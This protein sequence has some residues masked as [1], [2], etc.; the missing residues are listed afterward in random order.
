MDRLSRVW[1]LALATLLAFLEHP[2]RVI[3]T[4]LRFLWREFPPVLNR[5][6]LLLGGSL[7]QVPRSRR[8]R[9]VLVAGAIV[10]LLYSAAFYWVEQQVPK[11]EPVDEYVY[12]SQGWG[13]S[14][15]SPDRM[16][17][18]YSPQG[19]HIKNIRYDWFVKL[20]RPWSQDRFAASQ[21]MRGYGFI[22]DPSQTD[23]NPD[24]LPI[25]FAR[26]WDA[27]SA[28]SMLD[29]TCAACHT[30]ELQVVQNNKRKAVRID[31]GQSMHSITS[32][33]PGSFG[34]DVL[35][36]LIATATNPL[37]WS[38]FSERV[39][40]DTHT[41]GDS[42][43][44]WRD[45]NQ[46]IYGIAQQG[47]ID[48]RL[49]LYPVE[50]GFGRTDAL[51][52]IANNVFATNL[53]PK[54]YRPANA[55]V[56]YPP[57]W[58]AWKFDWVQYT[59]SV[60]QPLARNIGQALGTGA[61]YYLQDRYG[62]PV[63]PSERYRT[64]ISVANLLHIETTLQRLS[65]PV[66][67]EDLFGQK[68]EVRYRNGKKLFQQYCLGCHGPFYAAC[69]RKQIDAPLKASPADH[70]I[71]K[72]SS[73]QSIGT[74]PNSAINF[75]NDRY[76]LTSTGISAD[77]LRAV[78]GPYYREQYR[79]IQQYGDSKDLETLHNQTEEAY[80]QASLSGIDLSRVPS[81]AGLNYI[82]ALIRQRAYEDMDVSDPYLKMVRDGFGQLDVPQI[83][84]AY[85]ARPLEGMWAT[86]PF[87]HNGSVPNLYEL[88]LP[89]NQRSKTFYMKGRTFDPVKVGLVT[90]P[91][92]PAAFLFDTTLS[93]NSN[94]GHEFRAG[95]R[96]YKPGNPPTYGVIGP[97]LSDNQ[98]W[99]IIEY[100]KFMKDSD[101]AA[102]PPNCSVSPDD[103]SVALLNS[104]LQK[105]AGQ[106][107]VLPVARGGK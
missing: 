49:H 64:S 105:I 9:H 31:G 77:E 22:V 87:L 37:K 60:A 40:G 18:Y 46:V 58:N 61:A 78:L 29:L 41:L 7:A 93:G 100:L 92:D 4:G 83:K 54:N 79:R 30:G 65:P 36:S 39:L 26:V 3:R 28:S 48:H 95:Y 47:W 42:W 51:G 5:L 98:R 13:D 24:N 6:F 21:Y 38:R 71:I 94:A 15:T 80:V 14:G 102:P 88:L 97:E 8:V 35:A 27:P 101:F 10:C 50:E 44:L 17:Y 23:K 66:W 72:T 25:G 55:P 82:I 85:R 59:A 34:F 32:T 104:L 69:G 73:L 56:S 74:D 103:P 52:R 62:D 53:D 96:E 63:H 12:L 107:P 70:W 43:R 76:D 84:A 89:A 19:A 68:D 11:P 45:L 99:S 91:S 33:K 106:L 67:N 20:E 75:V 57:L 1:K 90:N 86:A 2:V 16:T 81:G